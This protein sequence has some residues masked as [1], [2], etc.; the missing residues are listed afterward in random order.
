MSYKP[1]PLETSSCFQSDQ[2][3]NKKA[4]ISGWNHTRLSATFLLPSRGHSRSKE[5]LIAAGKA[6]Q[7]S[8]KPA[9]GLLAQLYSG[10]Q[11]GQLLTKI[12]EQGRNGLVDEYYDIKASE[13]QMD[14]KTAKMAENFT[15]NRYADVLC[16]ETTRV[17]LKGLAYESDYINANYV[18]GFD[19]KKAYI[20][21]QG[22][23]ENTIKDQWKLMM[24]ENV[25]VIVMTTKLAERGKIKC[26]AY[27]P[28]EPLETCDYGK[29]KVVNLGI[30]N[31]GDYQ[32]T[33]LEATHKET[34]EVRR[35]KHFLFLSWPDYGV[36]PDANGFLKFL[37]HVRKAQHEFTKD[38]EWKAHPRGPPIVVHCSAGIGRTG[39]FIAIDISVYML[40]AT[41]KTNIEKVVRNIRKQRAFSIQM[42]DQYL[43]CHLALVQ[44][45]VKMGKL[46]T[47]VDVQ[48]LLFDE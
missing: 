37:F 32:I 1:E 18:D 48:T 21:T 19:H 15:K 28:L 47:S 16:L 3:T 34:K 31:K 43:F 26:D 13:P 9:Y 10:Q 7:S 30:A 46:K 41:A 45:A 8:A 23:L 42:P 40:D 5:K 22:P 17:K 38:I 24:Q 6:S 44:Y 2:K 25:R 14:F 27:W 36:P 11:I 39:T 29:I 33:L 20:S 4:N 12:Q 35:M